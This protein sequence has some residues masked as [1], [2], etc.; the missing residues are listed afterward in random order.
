MACNWERV[1]EHAPWSP[2]GMIGG[3]V[4]FRDRIWLIGGGTYDTPQHPAR[5]FFGEVWSSADGQ[6]WQC[7]T[8]HAPWHPR[9][10]H[11]TAAFDGRLWVLEGW[12]QSNR[13]DVWYSDDGTTWHELPATPWAASRRECVCVP[14]R[15]VDRGRKSLRPRRLE[16]GGWRLEAIGIG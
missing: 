16:A 11:E 10:Y 4:V 5:Q 2:R 3:S 6:E 15:P 7:H 1:I 14:Q 12:N 8:A 9:Q 13:N